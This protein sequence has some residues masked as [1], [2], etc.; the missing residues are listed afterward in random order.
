MRLMLR[1]KAI[2]ASV[3][4]ADDVFS[5]C[6]SNLCLLVKNKKVDESL[7]DEAVLRILRLKS[8][9]GLFENPYRGGDEE[10]EREIMMSEYYRQ[11]SQ[12]LAVK[13]D[14]PFTKQKEQDPSS[15][16]GA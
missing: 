5:I 1:D 7:I 14:R 13:I 4:I 9:L 3:D 11:V 2:K 6:E 15:S 12:E 8:K 10:L 16:K